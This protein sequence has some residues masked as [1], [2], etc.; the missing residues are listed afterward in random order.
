[1]R[2]HGSTE[3]N[4]LSA[5]RSAGRL[6]EQPVHADTLKYWSDL[7]RHARDEMMSSAFPPEPVKELIA[8]LEQEIRQRRR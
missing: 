8:R 4:L 6:R 2:L 1:M 5:I 7:I 3:G